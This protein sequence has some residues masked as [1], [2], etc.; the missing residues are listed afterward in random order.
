MALKGGDK[1][2]AGE[3]YDR[4]LRQPKLDDRVRKTIEEKIQQDPQV[5]DFAAAAARVRVAE[6]RGGELPTAAASVPTMAASPIAAKAGSAYTP[7]PAASSA[8]AG[9]GV[10]ADASFGD[11]A[12]AV[13]P[14]SEPPMTPGEADDGERTRS[15]SGAS[16]ANYFASRKGAGR[17]VSTDL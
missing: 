5:Q 4:V 15:Q 14:R 8:P 6:R 17:K 16:A 11:T 12:K 2:G 10:H 9:G 3:L 1:E 13:S 7:P